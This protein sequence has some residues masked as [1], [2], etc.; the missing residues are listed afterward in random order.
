VRDPDER[1]TL[2]H[3]RGRP[4]RQ[5]GA[6]L[7]ESAL[8]FGLLFTIIFGI[9][10]FGLQFKDSLAISNAVRAGARSASAGSRVSS[11]NVLAVNAVTT[12][13]AAV[14]NAAPQVLW[15]YKADPA[16]GYPVGDSPAGSFTSCTYC[17][18]YSWDSVGKQWTCTSGCDTTQSLPYP[19]LSWPST[20][21]S[22]AQYACVTA[23]GGFTPTSGTNT[24]GQYAGPDSIG[25]YLKILHKNVT[26]F[27]GSTVT[28]SDHAVARLEPVPLNQSCYG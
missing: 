17:E 12:G 14:G 10:E 22:A 2:D 7:V 1:S 6:V 18:R 24:S 8:V 26:G 28:L 19:A 21:S 25:I 15:I 23:P 9:V 13:Q 20:G 27:F 5:R 3:H 4:D 11:Y 16:T